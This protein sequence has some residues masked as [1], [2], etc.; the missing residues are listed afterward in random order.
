MKSVV[1]RGT[2]LAA[3]ILAMGTPL[4][5]S[6]QS[7]VVFQRDTAIWSLPIVRVA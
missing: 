2:K 5:I 6:T 3:S 7:S 4:S 1:T